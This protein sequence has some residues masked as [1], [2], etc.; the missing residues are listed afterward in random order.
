[1]NTLLFWS[2]AAASANQFRDAIC[3]FWKVSSY[4]GVYVS[5]SAL[6]RTIKG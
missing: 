5:H 2:M 1:M 3:D 6:G 4:S